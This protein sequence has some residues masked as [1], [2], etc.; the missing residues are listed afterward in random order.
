[1]ND[2]FQNFF[3]KEK[4]EE[5]HTNE[6]EV[7]NNMN[8]RHVT[9]KQNFKDKKNVNSIKN[10]D[11]KFDY[12][13]NKDKF[14][15]DMSNRNNNYMKKYIQNYKNQEDKSINDSK[16]SLDDRFRNHHINQ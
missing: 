9:I 2:R 16:K 15:E 3:S 12:S 4:F 8:N 6:N 10:I 5:M 13:E 11:T 7:M 14:H 1:M